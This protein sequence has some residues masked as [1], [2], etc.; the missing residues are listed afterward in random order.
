M[1]TLAVAVSELTSQV[2][3]FLTTPMGASLAV[4]LVVLL[5]ALALSRR[6]PRETVQE[7]WLRKARDTAGGAR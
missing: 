3:D 6:A 2:L 4:L 5:A 1:F 7:R